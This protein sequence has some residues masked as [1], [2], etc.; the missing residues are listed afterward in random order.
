M[1]QNRY[2]HAG[3]EIMFIN[4]HLLWK[5]LYYAQFR[6]N[7]GYCAG[8]KMLISESCTQKERVQ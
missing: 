2:K 4:R 3:K 7:L 1:E 5:S 8:P 6:R